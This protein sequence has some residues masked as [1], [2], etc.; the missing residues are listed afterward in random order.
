MF[1]LNL[2]GIQFDL[3]WHA[4]YHL[5]LMVYDWHK[6]LVE[7]KNFGREMRKEFQKVIRKLSVEE[8]K[9]IMSWDCRPSAVVEDGRITLHHCVFPPLSDSLKPR[10]P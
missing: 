4:C 8:R 6:L 7:N 5:L 10:L 3:H 1:L 2:L 9:E